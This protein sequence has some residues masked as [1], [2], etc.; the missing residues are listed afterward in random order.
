MG[1]WVDVLRAVVDRFEGSVI[2]SPRQLC[3]DG[4][5][6]APEWL[7]CGWPSNGVTLVELLTTH[8]EELASG[9]GLLVHH[10][11]RR[12][13]QP[14]WVAVSDARR[15]LRADHK[16]PTGA[17]H[18]LCGVVEGVLRQLASARS[19]TGTLLDVQKAGRGVAEWPAGLSVVRQAVE[20]VAGE[21]ERRGVR[22]VF[23]EDGVTVKLS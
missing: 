22:V 14:E 23:G 17:A 21:L 20:A 16:L 12:P 7:R 10:T 13:G 8:A 3:A 4:Q 18:P 11:P 19:W 1:S 2:G 5:D 9:H 15:E 6:V